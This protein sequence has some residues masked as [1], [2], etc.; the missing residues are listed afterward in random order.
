MTEFLNGI[1]VIKFYS[2]EKYFLNRINIVR[3]KELKLLKAK[4]YLDA[5]FVY[6]WACTPLI[7]S[8]LTF[9][10]YVLLGNVLLPAKVCEF[11][12]FKTIIIKV[13]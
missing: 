10:A 6:F 3:E 2:W 12:V 13:K 9:T 1:R 4:R 8:V 7:M 11:F 5:G